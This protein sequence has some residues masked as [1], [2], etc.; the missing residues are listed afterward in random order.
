[1]LIY[2]RINNKT[3]LKTKVKVK[4]KIINLNPQ[5]LSHREYTQHGYK[6]YTFYIPKIYSFF[7]FIRSSKCHYGV[8]YL[9]PNGYI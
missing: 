1:M 9:A 6:E 2:A 4:T 5:T 3:I 8:I 7:Y